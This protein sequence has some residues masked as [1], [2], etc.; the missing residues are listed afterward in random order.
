MSKL[1]VFASGVV[2]NSLLMLAYQDYLGQEAYIAHVTNNWY[3]FDH[4]YV[5]LILAVLVIIFGYGRK[6]T[7]DEDEDEDVNLPEDFEP[8]IM[9]EAEARGLVQVSI[10]SIQLNNIP[11]TEDNVRTALEENLNQYVTVKTGLLDQIIP[12]EIRRFAT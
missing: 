7:K 2:V 5:W 3:Q 12:E 4:Y 11:L 6:A 8:A 1:V 9:T 10:V